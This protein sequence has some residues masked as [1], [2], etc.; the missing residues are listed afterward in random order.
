MPLQLWVSIV[1]L[2]CFF[3][4][5]G[6]AYLLILQGAGFFH[7]ALGPFAMFSG[8]FSGWLTLNTP[9]P[10]PVAV[11]A[12]I[13]AVVV[14]S[15]LTE[16]LIVRPLAERTGGEELPAI[17]AVVAVLF[18]VQQFAG[19][20]FGRRPIPGRAWLSGAPLRVA[21]IVVNQH[22]LVLVAMTVVVFGATIAWLRGAR[23]GRMLRAVGDNQRAAHILGLPVNRIRLVS[24]ALAG[25]IVG[26]AGPLFAPKAG[27]G[28]L[29]GLGWTVSGFLALII[30]GVGR[31]WAPLVGGFL[32]AFLQVMASFYFG[33]AMIHYVTFAVA[34]LF[35]A[36][37]PEGLFAPRV[38]I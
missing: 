24:F 10:L 12:G 31:P 21:D 18:A 20:I 9:A 30:G 17:I 2:G 19:T 29:S 33:P 37:K 13:A 14:L 25:V 23:Y 35:F 6:L 4:I 5:I 3:G 7:F 8:M 28:F 34:M 1:E 26:I 22:A 32:L 38:R 16:V 11:A 15:I 36:F 27:V